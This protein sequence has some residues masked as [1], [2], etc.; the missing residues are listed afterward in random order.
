MRG[1]CGVGV[2][3]GVSVGAASCAVGRSVPEASLMDLLLDVGNTRL[4]WGLHDGTGWRG[5]GAVL[6][7]ALD[8]FAD[9]LA[10]LGRAHAGRQCGRGYG[11]RASW[12]L[13]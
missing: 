3:V 9:V 13:P 12:R 5:Q 7:S 4:K 11:R 6:L 2:G 10:S 1:H 8:G